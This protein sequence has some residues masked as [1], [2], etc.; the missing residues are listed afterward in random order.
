MA[1]GFILFNARGT[2]KF[3]IISQKELKFEPFFLK[4]EI[5]K[6]PKKTLKFIS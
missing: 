1:E 6:T 4:I 2:P 3:G 5:Y